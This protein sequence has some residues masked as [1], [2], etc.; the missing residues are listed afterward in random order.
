[1]RLELFASGRQSFQEGYE[2][3]QFGDVKKHV[4]FSILVRLERAQSNPGL[5]GRSAE[6]AANCIRERLHKSVPYRAIRVGDKLHRDD[7]HAA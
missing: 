3:G 1:L 4:V 2:N 7:G 5:A 6:D